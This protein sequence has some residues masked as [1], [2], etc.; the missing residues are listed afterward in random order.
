MNQ[1]YAGN[2]TEILN[3][4]VNHDILCLDD[5]LDKVMA[6][7]KTS[8]QKKHKY[9]ITPPTDKNGRW[10]TYFKDENQKRKI[11]RAQS[12]DELWDKLVKLY[13][14]QKNNQHLTFYRLY[15]EWLEYKKCITSSPN[16]IR[17]H[18]QH[19]RKYF[20]TSVLH[21]MKINSMD[22]LTLEKECNQIVKKFNLSRKEWTNAKTILKGMFEYAVR[23][24]YLTQNPLEK[25]S[26][27]V[28][29]RQVVKK[30]GKTQT[31]NTDE[32]EDLNTYL[33]C[34]YTETEDTIYLAI[35]INFLLG[36]R[37][38]ELVSLKWEDIMDNQLHIVREEVRD[39]TTNICT[40]ADHTKTNTDRYVFLVPKALEILQKIEHQD[41]YIFVRNGNRITSRQIAYVL[42]KYAERTGVPVKSSHKIRKTYASRLSA[43]G[44]PLD[45]IR[46]LLGHTNLET[47]LG[48][49]YNPMT[50]KETAKLITNALK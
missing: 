20:E 19:Y 8:V 2:D 21:N 24:G 25:I 15:Q 30:T 37:V 10:Q 31:Y 9:T 32:L 44:V 33:N 45:E 27:T 43:Y 23:K 6:S 49:I 41:E 12:E 18:E 29:Y 28:K 34:K 5:V 39:Q 50:E 3:Y 26:I 16:T 35:K 13:D 7:K 48:Y 36:L 42:E 40:V 22:E 14:A 47:T 17:R 11:V 1:S 38:A 46:E 4:A